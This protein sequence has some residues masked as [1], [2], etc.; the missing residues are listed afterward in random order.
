M[1][2]NPKCHYRWHAHP[3][4]TDASDLKPG[5][6]TRGGVFAA[7]GRN[8]NGILYNEKRRS[9]RA[10]VLQVRRSCTR[11]L[12]QAWKQNGRMLKSADRLQ[13]RPPEG[14]GSGCARRIVP[15]YRGT[16]G[17]KRHGVCVVGTRRG[18]RR[19]DEE[20]TVAAG[21]SSGRYGCASGR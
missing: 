15:V 7:V 13:G 2:P 18:G 9:E 1:C 8:P 14:G 17:V 21:N 6:P 4:A 10:G 5:Q 19:R 12:W 3:D 20:T 16:E 11:V